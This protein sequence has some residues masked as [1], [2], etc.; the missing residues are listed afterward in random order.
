MSDLL[1]ND[2]DSIMAMLFLFDNVISNMVP[3]YIRVLHVKKQNVL[4]NH[5]FVF[6]SVVWCRTVFMYM[7]YSL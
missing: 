4:C 1:L 7:T 6:D 5:I 2:G 3:F